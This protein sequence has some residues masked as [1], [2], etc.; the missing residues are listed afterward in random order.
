MTMIVA[1]P[2]VHPS[3]GQTALMLGV[4]DD[5]NPAY[6]TFTHQTQ[7]DPSAVAVSRIRRIFTAAEN[8]PKNN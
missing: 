2:A 4:T 7:S 3:L 5:R 8:P 1:P 6:G